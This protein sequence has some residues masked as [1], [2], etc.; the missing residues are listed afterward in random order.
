MSYISQ[1]IVKGKKYYYLEESFKFKNKLVKESVYFGSMYPSNDELFLGEEVLRRTCLAREHI[2]LVPPLT[3][4]IKNKTAKLLEKAKNDYSEKLNQLTQIQITQLKT[5]KFEN[6]IKSFSLEQK[7]LVLTKNL[8][9]LIDYYN[10][11][12]TKNEPLSEIKIK[13]MHSLLLE[14]K[15]TKLGTNE[16]KLDEYNPAQLHLLLTWY[17]EK[18]DLIHQIEFAAK[19][20]SKFYSLK[21]FKENNLVLANILQNYILEQKGFLFLIIPNKK[22]SIYNKALENEESENFQII[23]KLLIKETIRQS[24]IKLLII[25]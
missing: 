15:E 13:K 2:V 5:K 1:R 7:Q 11:G 23:T 25:N 10:E 16:N 6:L 14:T 3:E 20:C 12:I 17:K 4:F 19:F 24:R 8:K 22:I 18:N 21:L 9:N